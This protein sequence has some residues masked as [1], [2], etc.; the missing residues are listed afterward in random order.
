MGGK[1]V[2]YQCYEYPYDDNGVLVVGVGSNKTLKFKQGGACFSFVADPSYNI[3]EIQ[4]DN[5]LYLELSGH[6]KLKGNVLKNLRG[7]VR[8]KI[9]CGCTVY[10]HV[11]PTRLFKGYLTDIVYDVAPVDGAFKAVFKKRQIGPVNTDY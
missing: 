1:P 6:G 10:G 8:G 4:E 11:S 7:V 9:G 3:G 2:T 5:S